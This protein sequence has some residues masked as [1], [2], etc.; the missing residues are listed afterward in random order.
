MSASNILLLNPINVS[1]QRDVAV[2]DAS[3]GL[4]RHHSSYKS[5]AVTKSKHHNVPTR[6]PPLISQH[7]DPLLRFH[8]THMDDSGMLNL[9]PLAQDHRD[10]DSELRPTDSQAGIKSSGCDQPGGGETVSKIRSEYKT[11][12]P[13][14]TLVQVLRDGWSD[15]NLA[16]IT[17]HHKNQINSHKTNSKEE[18]HHK[19][20]TTMTAR[21]LPTEY[22]PSR[23]VNFT[24][25]PRGHCSSRSN[26]IRSRSI[27]IK[28]PTSEEQLEEIRQN[29]LAAEY[30]W[31]TWRMYN[32][33]IDY[34]KKHPLPYVHEDSVASNDVASS[35]MVSTDSLDSPIDF[36]TTDDENQSLQED[37]SQQHYPEYGE[38]FDLDL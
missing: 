9:I 3:T 7:I 34:R 8:K 21:P 15:A 16:G 38:V 37:K 4:F 10:V 31:A 12:G 32:R 5:N 11:C 1:L 14:M 2:D 28:R 35:N 17:P 25:L 27:A 23:R 24:S 30:D 22:L 29:S 19:M 26:R 6:R 18:S 13:L 20:A 36:A 33:I